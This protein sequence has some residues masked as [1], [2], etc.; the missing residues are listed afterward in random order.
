MAENIYQTF[1][2]L[3]EDFILNIRAKYKLTIKSQHIAVEPE[4][5]NTKYENSVV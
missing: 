4:Y 5:S 3:L 1:T 2:K